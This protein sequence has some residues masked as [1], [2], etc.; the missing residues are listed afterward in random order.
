MDNSEIVSILEG[1][2]RDINNITS[3]HT[4]GTYSLIHRMTVIEKIDNL[5]R[6]YD[7]CSFIKEKEVLL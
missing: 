3:K 2:R 5:I 7:E 1:L 4:D 6:Q